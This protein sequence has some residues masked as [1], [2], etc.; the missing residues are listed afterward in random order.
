M[1]KLANELIEKGLNPRLL[2]CGFMLP[3]QVKEK[4]E[5]FL[6][7]CIITEGIMAEDTLSMDIDFYMFIYT[8]RFHFHT[9]SNNI[10]YIDKIT[11]NE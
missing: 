3:G 1:D 2:W 8:V 5:Q 9:S 10:H 4:L 11:I 7:Y 6:P